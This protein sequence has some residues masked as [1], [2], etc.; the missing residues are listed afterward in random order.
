MNGRFGPVG[1]VVAADGGVRAVGA[2]EPVGRA[3]IAADVVAHVFGIFAPED[4]VRA[5]RTEQGVELIADGLGAARGRAGGGI[6]AA[7]AVYLAGVARV[8][9]IVGPRLDIGE[10][11]EGRR[12]DDRLELDAVL[13]RGH[14]GFLSGDLG[15]VVG[16]ADMAGG[17]VVG[18]QLA[19]LEQSAVQIDRGRGRPEGRALAFVLELDHHH[20]PDLP[21]RERLGAGGCRA[22][23]C[24]DHEHGG[25]RAKRGCERFHRQH[26]VM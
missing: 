10:D 17:E 5:R 20:V 23:R 26:P 18:D 15:E 6:D 2:A 7:V 11:A 25:D 3:V 14:G 8:V 19:L 21:V 4:L 22:G 1:E 13:V 16:Q 24:G 9:G 12:I